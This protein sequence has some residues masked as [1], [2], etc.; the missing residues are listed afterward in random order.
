M[1]RT[2][3]LFNSYVEMSYTFHL[4][5]LTLMLIFLI[6]S[7]CL[8]Y[9]FCFYISHILFIYFTSSFDMSH[10]FHLFIFSYHFISDL[11]RFQNWNFSIWSS[12]SILLFRC[13][14]H[15]KFSPNFITLSPTSYISKT[16]QSPRVLKIQYTWPCTASIGTCSLSMHQPRHNRSLL[17]FENSRGC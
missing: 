3:H 10:T 5:N 9:F 2:S 14:H 13:L 8:F 7:M 1:S 17:S 11:E 6:H 16:E 4:F 15:L 12:L